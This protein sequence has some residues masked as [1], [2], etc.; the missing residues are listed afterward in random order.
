MANKILIKRSGIAGKVPLATDLTP[1]ELAVNTIDGVIYTL[2]GTDVTEIGATIFTGDVTG[3]SSKGACDL[4]IANKQLFQIVTGAIPSISGTTQVAYT[5]TPTITSGTQIWS[6]SITSTLGSRVL[7]K[8]QVFGDHS[9]NNRSI[10]LFLFRDTT[11]IGAT[12][13]NIST[14]GTM[15]GVSYMDYDSITPGGTYVYSCRVAANGSGTWYINQSKAGSKFGG[16]FT[17]SFSL[18]EIA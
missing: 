1:S 5:A 15:N 3:V 18:T 14:S 8:T 13:F 9:V 2:K 17:N 10:S 16:G 7:I 11:L 12:V 6:Q 4:T